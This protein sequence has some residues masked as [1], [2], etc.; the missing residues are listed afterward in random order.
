MK[1]K[2]YRCSSSFTVAAV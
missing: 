2:Q 1:K